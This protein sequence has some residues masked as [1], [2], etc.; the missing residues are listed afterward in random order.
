MTNFQLKSDSI[1]NNSLFIVLFL[2][3]FLGRTVYHIAPNVEF[4]T[5]TLV[6]AGFYLGLKHSFWLVLSVMVLSDIVLGNT[7][8]FLFT[9]TGFLIPALLSRQ[10]TRA[11]KSSRIFTVL[12]L[13]STGLLFNLFFYFWTNFGVWLLD[14]WGMYSKDIHGLISCYVNALP[15]LKNQL[16]GTALSLPAGYL[17]IE[18]VKH[19]FSVQ[20]NHFPE[21]ILDMSSTD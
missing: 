4:V 5:F 17:I 14:S 3:A 6:M 18:T 8:I 15:F 2:V 11:K 10:T 13:T 16:T 20:K 19:I 12:F 7:N 9:W 1:I 21:K